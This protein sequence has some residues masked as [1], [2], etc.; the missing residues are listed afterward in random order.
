M[1]LLYVRHTWV[2]LQ[3]DLSLSVDLLSPVFGAVCAAHQ[4]LKVSVQLSLLRLAQ[5]LLCELEQST[6]RS[7]SQQLKHRSTGDHHF[8]PEANVTP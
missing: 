4:V 5:L 2:G 8:L 6:H 1:G 3:Q 7:S